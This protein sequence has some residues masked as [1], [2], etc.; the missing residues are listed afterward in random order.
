MGSKRIIVT[1][2]S[3]GIG[4]AL[5]KHLVSQDHEVLALSRNTESLEQLTPSNKNLHPLQTDI[6]DAKGLEAIVEFVNEK[7]GAVDILIHNAGALIHKPFKETTVAD[8]IK[9]YQVNV[10]AVAEL[11]RQIEQF[12][13]PAYVMSTGGWRLLM[14]VMI[15]L[16]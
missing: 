11:T 5:V 1:G 15:G 10:F 4:L 7:W 13:K 16:L 6:T 12:M 8:F 3:R 2:S 9:V 14:A